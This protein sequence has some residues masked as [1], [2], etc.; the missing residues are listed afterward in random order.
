MLLGPFQPRNELKCSFKELCAASPIINQP[1]SPGVSEA[2]QLAA[3][4]ALTSDITESKAAPTV[5][6]K[7]MFVPPRSA[8]A[9]P[10]SGVAAPS[11]ESKPEHSVALP[12]PSTTETAAAPVKK[13]FVPPRSSSSA[14]PKGDS[15]SAASPAISQVSTA[16]SVSKK[17][18]IPPTNGSEVSSSASSG[19]LLRQQK[20]LLSGQLDALIA[21]EQAAEK[22]SN[23]DKAA[24]DSTL[25]EFE[26]AKKNLSAAVIQAKGIYVF[27]TVI[28]HLLLCT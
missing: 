3:A 15:L 16:D 2:S 6:G 20:L 22:S 12:A 28:F 10:V 4:A 1:P 9:V 11:T 7:K 13:M 18:Q 17:A 21:E 25:V 27:V 14:L 26:A 8:A 19:D 5:S 23:V 24:L